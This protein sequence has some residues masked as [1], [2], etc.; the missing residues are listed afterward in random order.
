M[1]LLWYVVHGAVEVRK[2]EHGTVGV[3]VPGQGGWL[4]ELWD[5]NRDAEYWAR[6]HAWLAGVPPPRAPRSSIDIAGT[7]SRGSGACVT[8]P[9]PV[10]VRCE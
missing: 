4:G 9:V 7:G 10:S 8:V 3:I 2:R 5:P 6:P 1:P